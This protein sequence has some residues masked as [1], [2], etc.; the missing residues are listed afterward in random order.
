MKILLTIL[1]ALA[2]VGCSDPPPKGL[3]T[4]QSENPNFVVSKLFTYEG[5][6]VYRFYDGY[7]YVYYTNREGTT[8]QSHTEQQGK[9]Q[10]VIPTQVESR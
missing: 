6:T 1:A 10:V 7:R 5:V 2:L 9:H 8:M 4:V 3:I